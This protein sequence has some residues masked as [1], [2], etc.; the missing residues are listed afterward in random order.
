MEI[1]LGD[2][3]I[4]HHQTTREASDVN[5]DRSEVQWRRRSRTGM[6]ALHDAHGDGATLSIDDSAIVTMG[7]DGK[8]KVKNAADVGVKWGAVGGGMFGL[9]LVGLF[10]G[11]IGAILIGAGAGALIGKAFG[12]GID[13]KFLEQVKAAVTPGTSALCVVVRKGDPNV[14]FG[15]IRPYEGEIIYTNLERGPGGDAAARVAVAPPNRP[16]VADFL[17]WRKSSLQEGDRHGRP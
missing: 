13:K 7:Q 9:L 4:I 17:G 16:A 6:K 1:V 10:L 12:L 14:F 3:R 5:V 2:L 8:A 11:P 15:A